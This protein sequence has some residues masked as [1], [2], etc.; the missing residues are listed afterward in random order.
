MI[1]SEMTFKLR[2]LLKK[3]EGNYDLGNKE[4]V[5]KYLAKFIKQY[6]EWEKIEDNFIDDY[7]NKEPVTIK[8]SL[9]H[10]LKTFTILDSIKDL[11]YAETY[12][13]ISRILYIKGIIDRATYDKICDTITKEFNVLR[14]EIYVDNCL[15]VIF[16]NK[17]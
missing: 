6:K 14:K 13:Y 12:G 7:Y 5:E 2:E 3:L 11:S 4:E 8:D 17:K 1:N 10:P 9:K 16:E 15:F